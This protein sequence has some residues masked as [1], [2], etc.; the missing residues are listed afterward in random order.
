MLPKKITVFDFEMPNSHYNAISSVGITVIENGEITDAF[1]SLVNPQ[2]GFDPFTVKLTGITPESV[3]TAPAFPEIWEKIRPYFEDTVLC[4]HAAAG[5]LHVLSS[6]LKRYGI[7]W[8][9]K[10]RYICTL[11]VAKTVFPDRERYSLDQLCSDL[12]IPLSHHLASSD[13]HAAALL[14]LR[15]L[16]CGADAER[17]LQTFDM[18]LGH[19]FRK[20]NQMQ[21]LQ[22]V[23]GRL[24]ANRDKSFAALRRKQLKLRDGNIIG[25]RPRE[26][27]KLAVSL[28]DR[29]GVQYFLDALPHKYAEEDILHAYLLNYKKRFKSALAAT[30]AFLPY[31]KNEELLGILSPAVLGANREALY[32]KIREWTKNE[33]PFIAAFGMKMLG[34]FFT[35]KR[36]F[37]EDSVSLVLSSDL[38]DPAVFAAAVHFFMRFCSF[39]PEK[40]DALISSFGEDVPACMQKGKALYEADVRNRRETGEK[41]QNC[42]PSQP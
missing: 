37:R 38:S 17:F 40:F 22:S 27:K 30:E 11:N 35:E 15:S 34:R 8:V 31:V 16:A 9:N 41:K 29:P 12:D 36:Y 5:D 26:I 3:E 33:N 20:T 14:L 25:V 2:C 10:V 24:F 39:S 13:S 7:R 28:S 18:D 1:Y 42:N 4:A 32:E 21:F 23:R 6:V 19:P